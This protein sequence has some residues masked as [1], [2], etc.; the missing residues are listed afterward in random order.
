MGAYLVGSWFLKR[1]VT[2]GGVLLAGL[3]GIAAGCLPDVI[4][5]ALHPNHRAT[6]HSA[7]AGSMFA[8]GGYKAFENGNLDEDARLT[9]LVLSSAYVSHL[10]LDAA[11]PKSIPIA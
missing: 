3:G 2:F 4:E 9:A 11:T 5:P 6:F 10:I 7:A 1:R 8:F